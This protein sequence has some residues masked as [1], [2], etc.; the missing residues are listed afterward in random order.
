MDTGLL[1]RMLTVSLFAIIIYNYIMTREVRLIAI[2]STERMYSEIRRSLEKLT[3]VGHRN[4]VRL[5]QLD[6][7][8]SELDTAMTAD[9]EEILNAV[10]PDTEASP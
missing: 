9:H 2:A 5:S 4:E 6:G 1:V 3:E 8:V 10:G 7:K